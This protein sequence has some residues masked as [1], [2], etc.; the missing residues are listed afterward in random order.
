MLTLVAPSS[1]EPVTLDEAKLWCKVD[2]ADDDDLLTA[3]ITAAR[4]SAEDYTRRAFITQ[5]WKLS[6]DRPRGHD[7]PSGVY[8]LPIT[9]LCGELP[10]AVELPRHPVRSISSVTTFATDNTDSEFADYTLIGTKLVLTQ[11]GFWPSNLRNIG[12]VEIVTSNGYGDASSVP[13]AIKTAIKMH[14]MAMYDG[15]TVCDMPS[16]CE[17]LLRQYRVLR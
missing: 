6:L 14:V 2:A 13:E 12:C 16:S 9:A 3:L 15:R 4:Q 8:D 7:I 5:S 17:L 11:D 10:K 1:E